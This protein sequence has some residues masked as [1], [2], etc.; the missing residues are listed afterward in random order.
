MAAVFQAEDNPVLL[1]RGDPTEQVGLLQPRGQ[2][3]VAKRF[4][5]GTSEQPG[6]RNA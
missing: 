6:H 5:L 2:R 1:N 4:D 3:L